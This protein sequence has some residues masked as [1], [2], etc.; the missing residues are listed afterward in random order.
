MNDTWNMMLFASSYYQPDENTYGSLQR[1][2]TVSWGVAH[3]MIRNKLT[4]TFDLAYR[5]NDRES[6]V[7]A[8]DRTENIITGRLGLNYSINRF[9]QIFGHAEYQKSFDR[10]DSTLYDSYNWDYDR[11]RLSIGLRLTY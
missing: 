4:A 9:V 10:G 2:D 8:N 7:N 6:V 11:W 5:H 3:S 1:V